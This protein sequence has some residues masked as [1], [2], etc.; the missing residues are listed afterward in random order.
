MDM[1]Q[2]ALYALADT[3]HLW[4]DSAIAILAGIVIVCL[5]LFVELTRP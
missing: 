5:Y 3:M 1:I 4:R 2:A